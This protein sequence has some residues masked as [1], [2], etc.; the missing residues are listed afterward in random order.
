MRF[1]NLVK[2]KER[3]QLFINLAIILLAIGLQFFFTS[4][5]EVSNQEILVTMTNVN[6]MVESIGNYS[7]VLKPAFFRT[8]GSGKFGQ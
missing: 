2:Y 8:F 1:S 4:T 5:G 7:L 6:G 3:F